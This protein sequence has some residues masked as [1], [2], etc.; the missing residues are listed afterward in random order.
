MAIFAHLPLL[1]E[2]DLFA[3]LLLPLPLARA[4]QTPVPEAVPTM[5][6][7]QWASQSVG[8]NDP[9]H[10]EVVPYDQLPPLIEGQHH[11]LLLCIDQWVRDPRPDNSKP[12][13]GIGGRRRDMYGNTDGIVLVTLDTRAH[14]IMLTSII[15]DAIIQKVTSGGLMCE[16]PELGML[17]IVPSSRFRTR[18]TRRNAGR[19][20]A[21]MESGHTGYRPGDF[22]YIAP[23]T[24]DLVRGQAQFRPVI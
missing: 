24:I 18:V 12:P 13:T 21:R 3:L 11:Y 4:E 9:L 1:F 19:Y 10:F 22:I 5:T 20:S 23:D 15:R 2:P 16:I 8:E 17:G 6:L 7:E 14:R